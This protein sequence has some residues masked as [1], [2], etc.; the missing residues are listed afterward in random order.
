MLTWFA[1][2]RGE[3]PPDKREHKSA[4]TVVGDCS[5]AHSARRGIWTDAPS[6]KFL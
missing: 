5:D 3:I 1:D 6:E 4:S 2:K